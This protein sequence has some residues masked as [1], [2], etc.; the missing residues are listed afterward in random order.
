MCHTAKSPITSLHERAVSWDNKTPDITIP[1]ASEDCV[2]K[3]LAV[4]AAEGADQLIEDVTDNTLVQKYSR[5][6]KQEPSGQ[7]LWKDNQ[8]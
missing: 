5:V 4:A 6:S 7:G 8:S 2:Y 1:E 3:G